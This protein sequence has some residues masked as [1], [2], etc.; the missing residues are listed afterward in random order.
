MTKKNRPNH[1]GL[2][3]LA[4]V[5]LLHLER[6]FFPTERQSQLYRALFGVPDPELV[7]ERWEEDEDPDVSEPEADD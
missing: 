4:A 5:R 7:L 2:Q 1:Q 6:G 3:E